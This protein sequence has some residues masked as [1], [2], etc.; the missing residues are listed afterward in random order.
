MRTI[1]ARFDEFWMPEPNTGCHLWLACVNRSG[2]G[3]VRVGNRSMLAHRFAYERAGNA[4]AGHVLHHCDNPACVN[5]QHLFC[6][7][8]ADNV[9]DMDRKNRRKV[10]VKVAETHWNCRIPTAL[11]LEIR[12]SSTPAS[13]IARRHNITP[14]QVRNIR[15]GRQ[16]KFG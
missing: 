1:A 8:Q 9:R 10:S 16:R 5:P 13:E 12:A 11:V 6:G 3:V 7:S 2:Y 4:L 14:E 15:A